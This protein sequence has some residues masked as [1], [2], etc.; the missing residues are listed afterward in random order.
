[1][2]ETV[3]SFVILVGIIGIVYMLVKTG[4]PADRLAAKGRDHASDSHD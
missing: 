3:V 1:M 4:S 2:F